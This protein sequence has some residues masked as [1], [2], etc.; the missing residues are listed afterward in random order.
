[1]NP[2]ID[3]H[4][5]CPAS[6]NSQV[7]CITKSK[8]SLLSGVW[9]GSRR[10]FPQNTDKLKTTLISL[11]GLIDLTVVCRWTV[12]IFGTLNYCDTHGVASTYIFWKPLGRPFKVVPILFFYPPTPSFSMKIQINFKKIYDLFIFGKF[13]DCQKILRFSENS[14]NFG[15]LGFLEN[16]Q[17]FW[18]C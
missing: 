6:L 15:N 7:K 5:S 4:I 8:L 17:I 2:N 13:S 3:N 1:M 16:S 12:K 11:L 9:F 18:K 10:A 14:R